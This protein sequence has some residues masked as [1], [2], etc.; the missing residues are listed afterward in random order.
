MFFYALRLGMINIYGDI[1]GN[2]SGRATASTSSLI[3]GK[4][5]LPA[6]ITENVG[7]GGQII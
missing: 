4:T 2:P 3:E 1:T 7:T 6:S 5:K